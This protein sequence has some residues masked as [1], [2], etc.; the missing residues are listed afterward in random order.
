MLKGDISRYCLYF[1]GM[2]YARYIIISVFMLLTMKCF[3]LPIDAV[4]RDTLHTDTPAFVPMVSVKTI[5]SDEGDSIQ[6]VEMN[7][8]FVYPEMTFKKEKDRKRYNRLV[9]NVKKVLPLAKKARVMML[10]T[11]EYI[12]TLPTE[13]ARSAHLKLVE[14]DIKRTYTPVMK[15]LTFSQGKLLIKLIYRECNSSTYQLIKAFLGPMKAG[16]YQT[17]AWMFGASLTKQYDPNGKD[18]I[19]E[20]VVRMVEAGQL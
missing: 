6:Y 17:F 3:S 5:L 10:E 8:I 9:K 12:M 20:R 18:K 13:E 7:R 2:Y 16:F 15:K 4:V 11:Y 1:C 19:T 14:E